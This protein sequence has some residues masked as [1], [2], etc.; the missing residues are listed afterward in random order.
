MPKAEPAGASAAAR[1]SRGQGMHA[2]EAA[3]KQA[4][5][6]RVGHQQSEASTIPSP[7]A[8]GSAQSRIGAAAGAEVAAQTP[9]A[10]ETAATLRKSLTVAMLMRWHESKQRERAGRLSRSGRSLGPDTRTACRQVGE[11]SSSCTG[12]PN[13][14]EQSGVQSCQN[15]GS[16]PAQRNCHA[17]RNL[18]IAQDS[19]S[20][21]LSHLI[22]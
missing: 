6:L 8:S 14:A 10:S 1:V 18:D 2:T 16:M 21:H 15:M 19:V 11:P 12:P 3:I 20:S 5:L 9:A 7:G 17:T 22:A 13:N 4:L